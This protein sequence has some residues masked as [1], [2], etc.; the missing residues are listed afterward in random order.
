MRRY[1]IAAIP[2]DGIGPEVIAAGHQALEA[3]QR[4]EADLEFDLTYFDWGSDYYKS[5]G[6]MMP[7]DGLTQL[8]AFDAIFFGAVLRHEASGSL[9]AV[10]PPV[11]M[12]KLESK[13]AVCL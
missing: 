5:H 12:L 2:A 8:K 1:Q 3:V 11:E 4:R 6:V 9:V 13:R 10:G 7:E